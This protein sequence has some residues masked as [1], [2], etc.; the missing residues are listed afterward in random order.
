MQLNEVLIKLKINSQED[1]EGSEFLSLALYVLIKDDYPSLWQII[2][3]TVDTKVALNTIA[4]YILSCDEG[5]ITTLDTI[6]KI[7]TY[8]DTGSRNELIESLV[9]EYKLETLI[10]NY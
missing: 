8:G 4:S 7:L 3:K 2:T 6:D 9:D 1:L 10:S 5:I